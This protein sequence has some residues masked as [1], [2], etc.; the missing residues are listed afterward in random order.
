MVSTTNDRPSLGMVTVLITVDL[1]RRASELTARVIALASRLEEWAIPTLI[2]HN[3]RGMTC[4][5]R[6]TK[7]LSALQAAN[8]RLHSAHHHGGLPNNAALRNR[9]QRLVSTPYLMFLDADI[10]ASLELIEGLLGN[11]QRH[12]TGNAMAPCLYLSP[13]GTRRALRGTSISVLWKEYLGFQTRAFQ[14]LAMPSSVMVVRTADFAQVGGFDETYCGHGYEDF[15]FMVRLGVLCGRITPSERLRIDQAYRAPLLAMGLRAELSPW[16]FDALIS[17][18]IALHLHHS[19]QE[20]DNYYQNRNRNSAYFALQ[21]RKLMPNEATG[22]TRPD[23]FRLVNA[24]QVHCER[25]GKDSSEFHALLNARPIYLDRGPK[26]WRTLLGMVR[27]LKRPGGIFID[28]ILGRKE[29]L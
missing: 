10:H 13:S 14:H 25:E 4:D 2:V 5:R 20:D 12:P 19:R 29:P 28:N 8:V 7:Q 3:D 18:H 15:D 21:L 6:L 9:G 27:K 11:A 17:G 16:S 23:P 1:A 26:W 22:L 24:F